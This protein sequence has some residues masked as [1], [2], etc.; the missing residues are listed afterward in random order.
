M[1][2]LMDKL[3]E[4][5]KAIIR[6]DRGEK[7]EPVFVEIEKFLAENKIPVKHTYEPNNFWRYEAY[8]IYNFSNLAVMIKTEL[9]ARVPGINLYNYV[10]KYIFMINFGRYSVVSFTNIF[11]HSQNTR[12]TIATYEAPARL[13][14]EITMMYLHPKYALE[15]VLRKMYMPSNQEN[16]AMYL[17]KKKDLLAQW[18]T[19]NPD[20]NLNQ[21][22]EPQEPV[23]RKDQLRLINK[24]EHLVAY[25]NYDPNIPVYIGSA[26]DILRCEEIA[27]SIFP[28]LEVIKNPS[29]SFFD[30]RAAN[31]VFKTNNFIVVKIWELLDHELIPI[32]PYGKKKKAHISVLLRL[33]LTEHITYEM[34]G[35]DDI[36]KDKLEI[37]KSLLQKESQMITTKTYV[38]LMKCNYIG[39]NYPIDK[40]ISNKRSEM[41]AKQ[42][43]KK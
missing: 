29:K 31:R 7:L 32:I 11:G 40:Y 25:A 42:S 35:F 24:I 28:N 12:Y 36:S 30:P 8:P 43:N 34:L 5:S 10:F 38:N 39:R 22:I 37:F 27:R 4:E 9:A 13:N 16:L 6:A 19:L 3:I 23:F 41:S 2:H 20:A 14:K 18:D 33:A 15:E 1:A 17:S 26:S 21:P